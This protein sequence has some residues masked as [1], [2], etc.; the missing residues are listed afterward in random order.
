MWD[1]V[2]AG[3]WKTSNDAWSR[4][5]ICKLLHQRNR[6]E[7]SPAIAIEVCHIFECKVVKPHVLFSRGSAV[8]RPSIWLRGQSRPANYHFGE[9]SPSCD[10]IALCSS[11]A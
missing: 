7:W 6:T 3:F 9:S 11:L 2:R 5:A 10:V 1:G 4:N 8:S